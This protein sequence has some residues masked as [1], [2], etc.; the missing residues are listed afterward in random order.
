MG[1]DDA[2]ESPAGAWGRQRAEPARFWIG[3]RPRLWKASD[4]V[5]LDLAGRA[6]GGVSAAPRLSPLPAESG[7]DGLVYVPPVAPRLCEER[8]AMVE[9][10]LEGGRSVLVQ[11][12]TGQPM[13]RA[14]GYTVVW[15]P[16]AE[17]LEQGDE[18]SN[19][20]RGAVVAWPLIP[21]LLD[22]RGT[23]R[24]ACERLSGAGVSFVQ[25]LSPTLT[26]QDRRQ[27][28]KRLEVEEEGAYGRL[29]HGD[30][31]SERDFA[32]EAASC[33]L[34]VWMPRPDVPESGRAGRNLRLSQ[35]LALAG[36]MWLALGRS[37]ARGQVL[38]QA[39][40]WAEDT[41]IDAVALARE[42][43]LAILEW[44]RSPAREI[45]Q[46][47]AEGGASATFAALRREYLKRG[48]E[49]PAP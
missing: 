28:A 46:E 47:C 43:N 12:C 14:E 10:L 41:S 8:D 16:L 7:I 22:G 15:D 26:A 48:S 35:T 9:S 30:P 42:G 36:E 37:E 2:R 4:R 5:W 44:L 27:L 19:V 1:A 38:F 13:P 11:N 21:G 25:P 29:F 17:L 32:R 49:K 39:A 40:R 31:P 23:W 33:G 18:W 3:H 6:L 20:P 34:G 45:L 24:E